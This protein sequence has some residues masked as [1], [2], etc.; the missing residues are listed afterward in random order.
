MKLTEMKL[1][2]FL[3]GTLKIDGELVADTELFSS[4]ALDSVAMLQ[5]I[6][7]VEEEAGIR[8]RPEDVTLDNF[9]SATRIVRFAESQL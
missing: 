7:F 9:D 8:V 2:T 6:T 3:N 1:I 5:L 4:G